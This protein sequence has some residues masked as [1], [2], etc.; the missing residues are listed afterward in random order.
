MRATALM[1]LLV[2]VGSGCRRRVQVIDGSPGIPYTPSVSAYSWA[3]NRQETVPGGLPP[4]AL[5]DEATIAVQPYQTCATVRLRQPIAW[6]QPASALALRCANGRE[7]VQAFVAGPD[8]VEYRDYPFYVEGPM[9]EFYGYGMGLSVP[10]GGP[11][12]RLFR[13]AER[14]FP[15]CCPLTA[16]TVFKLTVDARWGM[17]QYSALRTDFQWQLSM[18]RR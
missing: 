1:V 17:G 12:E 7:K 13:V 6:D 5:L 10:L 18:P 14:T 8:Q 2:V 15:V 11:Q 3:G 4:N 16:G 9:L